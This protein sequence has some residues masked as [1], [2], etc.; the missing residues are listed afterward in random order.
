MCQYRR[1]SCVV[2]R[3]VFRF[4]CYQLLLHLH[5]GRALRLV[6]SED[7]LFLDRHPM[8][9]EVFAFFMLLSCSNPVM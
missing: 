9:S 7:E 8:L 6:S 4:I 5:A 1:L 2:S 3:R